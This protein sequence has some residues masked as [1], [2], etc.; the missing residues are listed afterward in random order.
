MIETAIQG[1]GSILVYFTSNRPDVPIICAEPINMYCTDTRFYGIT[2]P[3]GTILH[4]VFDGIIEFGFI[5][6]CSSQHNYDVFHINGCTVMTLV[7]EIAVKTKQSSARYVVTPLK[8][9]TTAIYGACFLSSKAK[10]R[11]NLCMM[12]PLDVPFL[13]DA[14]LADSLDAVR[15]VFDATTNGSPIFAISVR[16]MRSW[17]GLGSKDSL[18]MYFHRTKE[19][20]VRDGFGAKSLLPLRPI[21]AVQK[22]KEFFGIHYSVDICVDDNHWPLGIEPPAPIDELKHSVVIYGDR[23]WTIVDV[24]EPT[25]PDVGWEFTIK[26]LEGSKY[27]YATITQAALER[28]NFGAELN[29]FIPWFSPP[30]TYD[31]GYVDLG[32]REI[33]PRSLKSLLKKESKGVPPG[34]TFVV[35]LLFAG[36]PSICKY[37]VKEGRKGVVL[38]RS[39]R[40]DEWR[41]KAAAERK[42]KRKAMERDLAITAALGHIESQNQSIIDTIPSILG[43]LK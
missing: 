23:A 9:A 33:R 12:K 43:G 26:S 29:H 24:L 2:H 28:L 20:V 37:R 16:R 13:E 30:R 4:A 35:Y 19:A 25:D 18:A 1:D 41:E 14:V 7:D 27:L 40:L 36:Q 22:R 6:D 38:E 31:S 3:P 42:K 21:D 39:M 34:E 15:P 11:Y 17:V 5:N 8:S 10:D 32:I